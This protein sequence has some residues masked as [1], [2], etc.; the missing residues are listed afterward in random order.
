MT[1]LSRIR[2]HTACLTHGSATSATERDIRNLYLE[3]FFASLMASVVNFSATFVTRLGASKETIGLLSAL[4]F[5]VYALASIPAARFVQTRPNR[6][7]WVVGSLFAHRA[8]YII[9]AIIPWLLPGSPVQAATLMVVWLILM[10]LPLAFFNNDWGAL[11]GELVPERRRSFVF[12]RRAIISYTTVGVGSLIVGWVLNATRDH[13]P[14]NYQIA[15]LL[16]FVAS[17][18]SHLYISRLNINQRVSPGGATQ[19]LPVPVRLTVP[20]KRLLFNIAIYQFGIA[21]YNGLSSIHFV[22][23]LNGT[24]DWV[25]LNTAAGLLGGIIGFFVWER[26]LRR[27]HDYTWALRRAAL[28][29]W[30]YPVVFGLTSHL[31]VV[32]AG[33]LLVNLMHPGVELAIANLLLRLPRSEE[34]TSYLGMYTTVVS[35]SSLTAPLVGV[36]LSGHAAIGVPG[37]IL[38][39]GVLR[40]AGAFLFNVLPIKEGAP[41]LPAAVSQPISEQRGSA[42]PSV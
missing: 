30:I 29:T 15:Y 17:L 42:A 3:I 31:P 35:V 27:R 22:N 19:A 37:A 33:N 16:A 34:R 2:S 32:V 12:S 39:S 14:I 11:L 28:L 13:F 6:R 25:G 8:G 4:P 1:L 24:D 26:L 40:L 41:A 7:R 20:M 18:G 38:M 9:V 5:L 36:W 23:N 21:F 10:H